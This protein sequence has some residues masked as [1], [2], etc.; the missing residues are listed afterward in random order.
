MKIGYR[1]VSSEDQNLDR[2][3]LGQVD[4]IFE[5]KLSG[6]SSQNRPALLAMIDFAREGDAVIVYS[7]DRLARDLRDCQDIVGRLNDKGVS[8]AFLSENL[9]FTASDDDPFSKLQLHLMSAFAEFERTIIRRRQ[10]EGIEKAKAKGV[11]KG[12]PPSI[13][14][15][16]VAELRQR[17]FGPSDIARELGISRASVYRLMKSETG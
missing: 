10:R 15:G 14:A 6:G 5:E 3:D 2:Q 13:N 7:I 4:K 8:V 11:Y 1:R 16:K 12:R 9:K 17:G